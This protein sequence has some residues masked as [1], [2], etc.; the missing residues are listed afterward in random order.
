LVAVAVNLAMVVF[1]LSRPRGAV[2]RREAVFLGFLVT[3][4][5]VL[6]MAVLAY[7]AARRAGGR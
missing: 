7:R 4:A 1:V 6:L 5:A 2:G 3:Q